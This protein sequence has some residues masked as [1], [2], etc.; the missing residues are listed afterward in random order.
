MYNLIFK[1]KILQNTAQRLVI[2]KSRQLSQIILL[3]Q[4]NKQNI[5]L[6]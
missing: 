1:I 4:K 3:K 5:I 6:S 2:L